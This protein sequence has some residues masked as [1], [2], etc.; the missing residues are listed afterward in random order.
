MKRK[1]LILTAAILALITVFTACSSPK[2]EETALTLV[3]ETVVKEYKVGDTPDFS[4]VKAVVSYSDGTAE[5]V[6]ADK[7]TFSKLDTT[8]AGKKT[9]TVTYNKLSTTVEITV[10]SVSEATLESINIVESSVSKDATVGSAYDISGL[11]VEAIFSDG[12]KSLLDKESLEIT[13]PDT[14]T[15]GEKTL[16]VIYEGKSDSITVTVSGIK[17]IQIIADSI[18]AEVLVGGTLDTSK[19]KALVTYDNEK[20]EIITSDKLTV[21]EFDT[22]VVGEAAVKVSYKG[23]DVEYKV[24]VVG[25]KSLEINA[26]SVASTVKIFGTLDVS[27]LKATVTYSNDVVKS[28]LAS[29]LTIGSIDTSSVGAK[30]LEVSFGDKTAYVSVEVLGVKSITVITSSL[31]NEILLNR[32]LDTSAAQATVVYTDDSTEIVNASALTFGELDS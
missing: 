5:T 27:G 8:S 9:L 20:T 28:V 7:L 12:T 32:E 22:S 29:E 17:S 25:V 13:L 26:D 10:N 14:E 30:Q 3:D 4:G 2:K 15:V 1:I 11:Q 31:K 23:F 24:N 19:L 21:A 6:T 16:T 18:V